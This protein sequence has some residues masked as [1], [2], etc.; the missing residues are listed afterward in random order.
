[1][2]WTA[3]SRRQKGSS[4]VCM[5][6]YNLLGST[7][8]TACGGSGWAW[9]T[10]GPWTWSCRRP[11]RL[12]TRRR[13]LRR[14]SSSGASC[15]SSLST[16][17]TSSC[18]SCSPRNRLQTARTVW[19]CRGSGPFQRETRRSRPQQSCRLARRSLLRRALSSSCRET[20]RP[21]E[22]SSL[23]CR[24]LPAPSDRKLRLLERPMLCSRTR[25][26]RRRRRRRQ[27]GGSSIRR[28]ARERMQHL[29]WPTGGRRHGGLQRRW[30]RSRTCCLACSRSR[31]D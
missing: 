29:R 11:F 27:P 4:G 21:R 10:G 25:H 5:N 26:S 7:P 13:L 12:Q 19:S 30:R 17:R 18:Q 1:M 20:S 15:S 9:Q 14:G 28:R 31:R 24:P 8:P 23:C 6:R 3:A 16:R 22:A 2:R